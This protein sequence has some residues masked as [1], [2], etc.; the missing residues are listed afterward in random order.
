MVLDSSTVITP[1]LPTISMASEISLPMVSSPA[2]M[3]ATCAMACLPLM[4]RLSSVRAETASAVA[5]SMPR[6][7][8]MG[9]A[10][11]A[12]FFIPSRTMAC[13]SR[14]AVVVPSPATSL[15]LVATSLISC[16][17]MFSKGSSNSTSLAMVT[18]S[19][20]MRGAPYFLSSTTLRPLGPRV[21]FTV[22]ARV[23]RPFSSARRASSPNLIC[24][25]ITINSFFN[26]ID[27]GE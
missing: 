26:Q 11:A 4:G 2:E 7:S 18:P 20:V 17:P 25:A 23:F 6:R 10:P 9:L 19:L 21:I 27:D 16:A 8:T 1:S 24:L 3:E 13:A 5:A 15:V 14:V 12:R 22:S